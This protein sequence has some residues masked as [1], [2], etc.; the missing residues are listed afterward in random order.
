MLLAAR[1]HG[2]HCFLE[3][4]NQQVSQEPQRWPFIGGSI[5]TVNLTLQ[6]LLI[7]DDVCSATFSKSIYCPQKVGD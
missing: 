7:P 6:L 1:A 2:L 5:F 3:R 4:K